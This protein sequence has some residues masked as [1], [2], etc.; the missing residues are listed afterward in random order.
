MKLIEA[1]HDCIIKNIDEGR[2]IYDSKSGDNDEMTE[3]FFYNIESL[4]F[5]NQDIDESKEFVP[6]EINDDYLYD[7]I[8]AGVLAAEEIIYDNYE[9]DEMYNW[10]WDDAKYEV[11]ISGYKFEYEGDI[12]LR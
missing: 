10:Y 11:V 9:D 3:A 8:S 12:D 7:I 5:L 2:I 4:L 1:L 6:D